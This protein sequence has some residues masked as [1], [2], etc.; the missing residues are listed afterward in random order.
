MPEEWKESVILTIYKKDE[1]KEIVL[2]IET[3][4]YKILCNI[5]LSRLN[6]YAEKIIGDHQCGFRCSR[7]ATDHII[8]IR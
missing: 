6:P 7:S 1:K 5:L 2:I 3:T 8:C 4:T